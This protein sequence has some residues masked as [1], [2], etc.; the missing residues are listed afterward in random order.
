[1]RTVLRLLAV[2]VITTA[3]AAAGDA[4]ADRVSTLL[5]SQA[6][7]DA[8]FLTNRYDGGFTLVSCGHSLFTDGGSSAQEC[9]SCEQSLP[10]TGGQ[11]LA[12]YKNGAG[13]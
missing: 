5:S 13:L 10:V 9:Y 12:C 3:V 7:I 8:A 4:L 1:M 6:V 11:I 2:A